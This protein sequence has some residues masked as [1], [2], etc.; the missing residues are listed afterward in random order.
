MKK[1]VLAV[2]LFVAGPAFAQDAPKPEIPAEAPKAIPAAPTHWTLDLDQGDITTIN[3]C[4]GELPYKIAQPFVLKV[5]SH[6]K[7]VQ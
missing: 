5:Q 6:L 7:P 4:V 1:L 2:A 3:Q